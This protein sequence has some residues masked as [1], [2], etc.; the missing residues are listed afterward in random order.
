MGYNIYT[1]GTM[2]ACIS[3]NR[4][5]AIATTIVQVSMM[6]N[7]Q[8]M[9]RSICIG[10]KQKQSSPACLLPTPNFDAVTRV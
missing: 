9:V 7:V 3:I 5:I 4:A 8:C 6:C 2:K 1:L 10:K